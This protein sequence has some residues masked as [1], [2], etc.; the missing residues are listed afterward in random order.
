[1]AWVRAEDDSTRT[2]WT[3]GL[4]EFKTYRELM[5]RA[6]DDGSRSSNKYNNF[7][8]YFTRFEG[9]ELYK[10][11]I[12]ISNFKRAVCNAETATRDKALR[13]PHIVPRAQNASSKRIYLGLPRSEGKSQNW[14]DDSDWPRKPHWKHRDNRD[15]LEEKD[16]GKGKP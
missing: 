7:M 11:K 12:S 16:A 4:L 6:V 9:E 2:R 8:N 1:K 3:V 5:L 14:R 10:L 13:A 15:K